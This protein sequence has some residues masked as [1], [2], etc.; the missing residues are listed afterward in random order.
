[1]GWPQGERDAFMEAYPFWE[2]AKEIWT[3][4][5]IEFFDCVGTGSSLAS[6]LSMLGTMRAACAVSMVVYLVSKSAMA[7]G[8]I[9]HVP[10][11]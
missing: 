3:I 7:G 11:M 9:S 2:V 10:G 8:R 5:I 6:A 1:M 4:G